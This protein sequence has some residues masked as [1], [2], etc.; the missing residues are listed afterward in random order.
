MRGW[1]RRCGNTKRKP[2]ETLPLKDLGPSNWGWPCCI[3]HSAHRTQEG[4][5]SGSSAHL[6]PLF[7]EPQP[8]L[9]CPAAKPRRVRRNP[10]LVLCKSCNLCK[11]GKGYLHP[12]AMALSNPD[13]AN[14]PAP[15][16]PGLTSN[17]PSSQK[18][19]ATQVLEQL[20]LPQKTLQWEIQPPAGALRRQGKIGVN[21]RI[22]S[23][24]SWCWTCISGT[25]I[26]KKYRHT[27]VYRC[28]L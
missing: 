24:W 16:V 27:Y 23:L 26:G 6:C 8:V 11:W 20:Y 13:S 5:K 14:P 25:L 12:G 10:F 7:E 18:I 4:Q 2:A 21:P 28:T 19:K 17:Q 1:R 3:M 15:Q 9:L 22:F